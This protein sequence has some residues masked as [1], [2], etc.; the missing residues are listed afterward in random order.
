MP[1]QR[2]IV[3][4]GLAHHVTQR[5]NYRQK[6]FERDKDFLLYSKWINQYAQ[7]NKVAIVAYCLMS[8]H[9]HFVVIPGSKDG[10]AR[11]FNTAHMRYSQYK[12]RLKKRK[13]H[14]WQGRF[15]SC[16]LGETHLVNAIRYVEQNPVRAKLTKQAWNYPWS[17]AGFHVNQSDQ[18]PI[19]LKENTILDKTCWRDSIKI[20]NLELN[21]QVRLTTQRGLVFGSPEFI[22]QVQ[23]KIGRPLPS[24][25]R[26]RPKKN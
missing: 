1:R 24:L 10:L 20:E 19:I 11:T 7:K 22:Q 21:A 15:F 26:G 17:S 14:L 12:N 2:R 13:G 25:L 4:P 8:N 9:V 3:I 16:V 6:V 18:S 5:G 23:N